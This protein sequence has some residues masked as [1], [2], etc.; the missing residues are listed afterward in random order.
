MFVSAAELDN[1]SG[2]DRMGC[3]GK[4]SPSLIDKKHET[5]AKS[6]LSVELKPPETHLELVLD[7]SDPAL[8]KQ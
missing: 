1:R 4:P 3:V 7:P 6:D 8:T 5:V 2:F